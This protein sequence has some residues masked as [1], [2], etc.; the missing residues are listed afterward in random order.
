[1]LPNRDYNAELSI[2]TSLSENL[3]DYV[4]LQPDWR[5]ETHGDLDLLVSQEHWSRMLDVLRECIQTL[6]ASLVK[7]YE[8]ERGIICIVV[9]TNKGTV[10][11]DIAITGHC[12]RLFGLNPTKVLKNK[13]NDSLIPI[14]CHDDYRIYKTTKHSFKK[15]NMKKLFRLILHTLMLIINLDSFNL[16]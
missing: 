1:M 2:L 12:R 6:N 9:L 11:L 7:T 14:I 10:F 16:I 5:S 8:I 15:S 13:I 4:A 3:V